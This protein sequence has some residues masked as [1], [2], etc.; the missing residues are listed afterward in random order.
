MLVY[1]FDETEITRGR[2]DVGLRRKNKQN[3]PGS[4]IGSIPE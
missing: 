1:C 4:L 3:E 2:E